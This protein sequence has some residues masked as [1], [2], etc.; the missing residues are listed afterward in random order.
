MPGLDDK[1]TYKELLDKV[2]QVKFMMIYFIFRIFLF[3]KNV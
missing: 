3:I 1:L 2:C